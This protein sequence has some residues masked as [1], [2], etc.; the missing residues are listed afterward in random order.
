MYEESQ[1]KLENEM[2]TNTELRLR[3]KELEFSAVVAHQ[4]NPNLNP[5]TP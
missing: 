3:I 2:R 1:S 4:N 5:T